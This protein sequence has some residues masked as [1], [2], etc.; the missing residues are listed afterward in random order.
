MVSENHAVFCMVCFS[1]LAGCRRPARLTEL[2][3][4]D[5]I[6]MLWAIATNQTTEVTRA[7]VF[8]TVITFDRQPIILIV[9]SYQ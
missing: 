9:D 7:D 2:E 4:D 8:I 3:I 5:I 1:I 6:F